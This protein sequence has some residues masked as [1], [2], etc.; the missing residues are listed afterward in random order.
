MFKSTFFKALLITMVVSATSCN[1]YLD[2]RPTDGITREKFWQSKEQIQSAV[3]GCY[4]ALQYSPSGKTPAELFFIWG[5]LRADMIAPGVGISVDENNIINTSI[6]PTNTIADWRNVYRVIN[7]CN[8]VIDF[9][10]GVKELDNTLTQEQLN[11]YLSEALTIRALMYFYLVRTFGDVPLKL[12]STSSD[13]ELVQLAKT[14]QKDVL[15]QIVADLK[16]AEGY[17]VTFYNNIVFDKG[18]VTRYTV[19]ALQADVYLWMDNYTE[20][21]TACDKIISSNRFG[22]VAGTY[23]SWYTTLYGTGNSAEGIFELQFDQQI[24]NPYFTMFTT[25][26]R[27]FTAG[28]GVLDQVY[29]IDP[30]DENNFDLRG[31]NGSIRASD[32]SIYKYIGL[33]P[34]LLRTTDV[35]YAHWIFYRYADVLLMKAEACANVQRGQ[36]TLDIISTVR[37]RAR[38][39]A[40]S[41][42][43]PAADDVAGL[44]DY[45]LAERS[46]EFAYEGKR[47]YD[48]LRNAKRNNYARLDI[49]NKAAIVSA[50]SAVQ[51]SALNKLKDHGSHYLPIFQYELQTDPNLIQNPFY[52]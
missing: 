45:V 6:L 12:K 51:Q 25:S 20:C 38:A 10:P 23:A 24:L 31:I 43:S 4:N 41:A 34:E 5:E 52:R 39:L 13:S 27:R 22:L 44:T 9:A 7:F 11:G 37:T 35:S 49:L 19:N 36:E 1:N 3:V 30:V 50:P 32:L 8:T 40:S 48:L 2:L 26:R 21:I 28:P 18:R 29:T 33:G 46:R 14:A 15:N 16:L 17:A 42:S 47:W